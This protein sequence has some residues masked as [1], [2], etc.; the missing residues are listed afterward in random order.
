MNGY[1][2]YAAAGCAA[3]MLMVATGCAQTPQTNDAVSVEDRL[4]QRG[5]TIGEKVERIPNFR[6]NDWSYLDPE[7]VVVGAGPSQNFLLALMG[8][9]QGLSTVEDV[10]FSTTAGSLTAM[11][12]LVVQTS[13]GP[14]RCPIKEIRTL[15][16]VLKESEAAK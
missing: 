14:E 2:G 4:A 15:N 9:C 13:I 6:V 7:H 11:D 16:K 8:R 10:G 3:L 1:L 5:F 12:K